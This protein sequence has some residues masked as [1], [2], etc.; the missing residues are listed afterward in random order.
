MGF[1][2]I[3]LALTLFLMLWSIVVSQFLIAEKKKIAAMSDDLGIAG[4][5]S[6]VDQQLKSLNSYEL[7]ALKA[8]MFRYNR[9][10]SSF[11][12]KIVAGLIGSKKF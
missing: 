10:I 4:D 9:L 11:P 2:P 6:Q 7:R 8:K 5:L 3:F 12:Y 1:L